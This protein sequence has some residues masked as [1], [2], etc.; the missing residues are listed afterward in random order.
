[1]IEET[2]PDVSLWSSHMPVR[3]VFGVVVLEVST[4]EKMNDGQ[5]Q[6]RT[7]SSKLNAL[8]LI[9]PFYF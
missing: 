2:H 6:P 5:T 9:L 4:L 3:G 8:W 7:A 1:M